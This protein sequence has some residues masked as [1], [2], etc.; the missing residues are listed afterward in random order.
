MTAPLPAPYELYLCVINFGGAFFS[1]AVP[2]VNGIRVRR[3]RVMNLTIGT[4]YPGHDGQHFALPQAG[5]LRIL[6][7]AREA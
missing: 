1:E 5:P 6:L 2:S 3:C 4:R 7:K